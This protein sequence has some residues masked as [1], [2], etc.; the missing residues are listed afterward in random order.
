MHLGLERACLLVLLPFRLLFTLYDLQLGRLL[1]ELRAIGI[2]RFEQTCGDLRLTVALDA[3][4]HSTHGAGQLEYLRLHLLQIRS[5]CLHIS[6][7]RSDV[8]RGWRLWLG[9]GC[10]RS[11]ALCL[12][13][14]GG[15]LEADHSPPQSLSVALELEVA[16]EELLFQ[17]LSSCLA[18]CLT[19][20]GACRPF[21][22]VIFLLCLAQKVVDLQ[23]DLVPLIRHLV[24]AEENDAENVCSQEAT[25]LLLI[26]VAT[27]GDH[28][29]VGGDLRCCHSIPDIPAILQVKI[30][31]QQVLA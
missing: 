1:E 9:L 24:T 22:L 13:L 31:N 16:R 6:Y 21:Q 7:Q 30:F 28:D 27:A 17:S 10:G 20:C 29:G 8:C 19:F 14:A 26:E 18:A 23:A 3:L 12:H 4:V 11:L 15:K 5:C 25:P 2:Q